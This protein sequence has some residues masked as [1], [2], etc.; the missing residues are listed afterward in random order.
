VVQCVDPTGLFGDEDGDH[1]DCIGGCGHDENP[2]VIN[3]NTFALDGLKGTIDGEDHTY[4]RSGATIQGPDNDLIGV[5]ATERTMVEVIVEPADC[6]SQF[7]AVV[8]VNDGFETMTF[9]AG[10]TPDSRTARTM[11]ASPYLNNELPFYVY[12]QHESNYEN[13]QPGGGSFV[14][15]DDYDYIVRFNTSDFSPEELGNLNQSPSTAT[16]DGQLE[17]GGDI[18]YYRFTAPATAN[19]SV[20]VDST[21][22]DELVLSVIGF[23]T[24]EGQLIL[25]G[26]EFDDDESGTVTIDESDFR[27]CDGDCGSAQGEFIFAVTDYNG[28]AGDDFSYELTVTVD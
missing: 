5:L 20:E 21:G 12:V 2:V 16:A 4:Q 3:L 9:N 28:A 26:S 14:G 25:H 19:V 6:D 10:I 7:S 22:S 23:R 24:I 17:Q 8:Q 1:S 18:H 13:F 15:G 27:T 11:V